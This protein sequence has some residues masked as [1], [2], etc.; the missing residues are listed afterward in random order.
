[1]KTKMKFLTIILALVITAGISQKQASAQQGRVSFQLFYDQLS[2]YG[3]WIDYR[4]YG[5]VWFPDAGPNFIPYSTQGHWALSNY[6]WTWISNYNWGWAPFHYGRWDYDNMYGWFW[7][8]DNE[9]GP[10]WVDWRRAD[11]YYGWRPMGS[12]FSISFGNDYNRYNDHWMFVRDSYIGRKNIDRYYANSNDYDRIYSN[13]ARINNT[14]FDRTRNTSYVSGPTGADVLRDAGTRIKPV[15]IQEYN[16][17]GQDL[18]GSQL[19]LYRPQVVNNSE[20]ALKPAPTRITD[21]NEIKRSYERNSSI[22]R[23]GAIPND[24]NRSDPPPVQMNRENINKNEPPVNMNREN[25]NKNEPPVNMNRENIN[26]NEPPVNMNR[27]NIN[28]NEPPVNMNRE[29]INKNEPP[30]Q[31]QNVNPSKNDKQEG[32]QNTENQQN[33]NNVKSQPVQS[34]RETP[35]VNNKQERQN[36]KAKQKNNKN[37]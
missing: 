3:Q 33:N 2:P 10:S 11:G 12:R 16:Q 5:Y 13:S 31:Q 15:T 36:N 6:G 14:Y 21:M 35:P 24:Y 28:K 4:N 8:P 27:E 18:R 9:W 1:M 23:R 32:L 20:M 37:K 25:I 22:P 7:V 34:R 30:V 29:N 26:K 17:P 19:R